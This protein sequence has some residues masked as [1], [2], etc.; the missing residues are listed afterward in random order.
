M[1]TERTACPLC[2]GKAALEKKDGSQ[3]TH[4]MC[5]GLCRTEFIIG[6]TAIR[7]LGSPEGAVRRAKV[8]RVVSQVVPEGRIHVVAWSLALDDAE[9]SVESR[10]AWMGR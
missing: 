7:V 4:V 9:L 2:D 3:L 6:A 8:R 5:V 10:E 1:V